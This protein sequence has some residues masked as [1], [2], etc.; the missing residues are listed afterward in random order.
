MK[1]LSGWIFGIFALGLG[2]GTFM[3]GSA[4]SDRSTTDR[5]L[6]VALETAPDV[7]CGDNRVALL[8]PVTLDG[9]TSYKLR[10]ISTEPETRAPMRAPPSPAAPAPRVVASAPPPA[11]PVVA[12]A[13]APEPEPD[14]VTVATREDDTDSRS[15]KESAVVIGGSAGAGAGVGA[16]AKGKKGAAVGAA[17]GAATGAAYE[18]LKRDKN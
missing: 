14:P 5:A 16:I 7:D 12:P 13:P 11:V 1:T 10:C 4:S 3:S 6:E 2:L 8:E 18:L 15:W 9:A 17:I